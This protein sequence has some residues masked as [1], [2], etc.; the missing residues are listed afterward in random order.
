MSVL[1]TYYLSSESRIVNLNPGPRHHTASFSLK[2]EEDGS[3]VVS[4]AGIT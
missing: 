3:L 1:A 2:T 4:D